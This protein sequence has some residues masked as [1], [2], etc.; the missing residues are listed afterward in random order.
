MNIFPSFFPVFSSSNG[1]FQVSN[2]VQSDRSETRYVI[3]FIFKIFTL[4][5]VND[6][7]G[8]PPVSFQLQRGHFTWKDPSNLNLQLLRGLF[9]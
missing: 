9:V 6:V 2:S 8:K 7:T 5:T 4:G 1:P 3:V